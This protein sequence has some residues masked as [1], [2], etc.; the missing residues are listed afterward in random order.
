MR[1]GHVSLVWANPNF[2]SEFDPKKLLSLPP[3]PSN[4]CSVRYSRRQKPQNPHRKPCTRP[5]IKS[6]GC[7]PIVFSSGPMEAPTDGAIVQPTITIQNSVPTLSVG[8]VFHGRCEGPPC[9]AG[10]RRNKKHLHVTPAGTP[11]NP[12]KQLSL[13]PFQNISP[14][15]N[16]TNQHAQVG[17]FGG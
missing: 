6:R 4:K 5:P 16:P 17:L 13:V 12:Q 2:H 11:G 8:A 1:R 7:F 9:P 14:R 3:L 15:L 10:S